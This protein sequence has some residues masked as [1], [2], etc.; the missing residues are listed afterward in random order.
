[1]TSFSKN[2]NKIL[3]QLQLGIQKETS[4][5]TAVVVYCAYLV[6]VP[7]QN[8][9]EWTSRIHKI[10]IPGFDA[11]FCVFFLT[12]ND[13]SFYLAHP[14]QTWC[15]PVNLTLRASYFRRNKVSHWCEYRWTTFMSISLGRP[16]LFF[17]SSL[18]PFPYLP[19]FF[20]GRLMLAS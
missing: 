16:N 17:Q 18:S 8:F 19:F 12:A 2:K 9:R 20:S 15:V 14:S 6:P 5:I 1:M 10:L 4:V 7:N 11:L 3:R 13:F